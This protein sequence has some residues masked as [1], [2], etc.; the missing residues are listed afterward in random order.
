M[1]C[2]SSVPIR[3]NDNKTKKLTKNKRVTQRIEPYS[4]GNCICKTYYGLK[5]IFKKNGCHSTVLLWSSLTVLR[6]KYLCKSRALVRLNWETLHKKPWALRCSISTCTSQ[7][8][9]NRD[10]YSEGAFMF[11]H[12]YSSI[13]VFCL[14]HFK[15]VLFQKYSLVD[16]TLH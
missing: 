2:V 12:S 10:M 9:Y 15:K 13:W 14:I 3:W 16:R 1:Q 11:L 8:R 7:K 5:S 6:S 4:M